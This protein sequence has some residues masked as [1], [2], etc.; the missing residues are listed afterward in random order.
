[1]G[2]NKLYFHLGIACLAGY[3]WFFVNYSIT[4]SH[5]NNGIETG[6]LIK[7]FTDI[8]CP[9]CG[10]TRSLISL[11]HGHIIESLYWNPFGIVLFV[12]MLIT[13]I[14][15]L[16]DC[17]YHRASLLWFYKKTELFLKQRK[18]AIPAILLVLI[19]WGWNIYKGL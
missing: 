18:V 13:P 4:Y 14:W 16:V 6:C 15:L 5:E 1:M 12:I 10:A 8:P 2:R 17:L 11:M 9:S 3:I 19:N 7:Q